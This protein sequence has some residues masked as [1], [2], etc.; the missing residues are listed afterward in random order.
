MTP[1]V[2]ETLEYSTQYGIATVIAVVLMLFFLGVFVIVL[3]WV[4]RLTSDM[5]KESHERELALAALLNNSL[6]GVTDSLHQ[7]TVVCQQITQ[8]LKDGFDRMVEIGKYQREEH[9]KIMKSMN[10]NQERAEQAREK[11]I[12]AVSSN[13]CKA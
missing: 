13:E 5:R 11:I 4:F 1:G 9:D 3:R 7:N 2:K 6:K 8:S 10:D 12:A